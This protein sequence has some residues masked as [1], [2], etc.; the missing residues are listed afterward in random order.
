VSSALLVVIANRQANSRTTG[1]ARTKMFLFMI[2]NRSLAKLV[3]TTARLDTAAPFAGLTGK[4]GDSRMQLFEA[5]C[6]SD[7]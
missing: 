1:V 4:T 7:V 6:T 3:N 2:V 5:P